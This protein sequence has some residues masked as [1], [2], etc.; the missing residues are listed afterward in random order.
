MRFRLPT[1]RRIAKSTQMAKIMLM[2][3]AATARSN[4]VIP[5]IKRL[6]VSIFM[7]L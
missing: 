3:G 6:T 4:P 7:G 2:G 1:Y 5:G